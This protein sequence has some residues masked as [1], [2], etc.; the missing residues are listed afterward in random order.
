MGFR[1]LDVN[2]IPTKD[3]TNNKDASPLICIKGYK[4][5]ISECMPVV[6]HSH[7]EKE[8]IKIITI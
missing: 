7:Y 8:T 1:A 6:L 5:L 3:F 4:S 2:A